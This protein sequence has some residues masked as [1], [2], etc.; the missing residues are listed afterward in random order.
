MSIESD[1]FYGRYV[2][3]LDPVKQKNFITKSKKSWDLINC[4]DC[5]LVFDPVHSTSGCM[6]CGYIPTTFIVPLYFGMFSNV[7]VIRIH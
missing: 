1:G 6:I 3:F 5:L 4:F 7:N 2:M